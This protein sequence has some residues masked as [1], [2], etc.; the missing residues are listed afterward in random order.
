MLGG[1]LDEQKVQSEKHFLGGG[2]SSKTYEVG[3][4]TRTFSSR[5][6]SHRVELFINNLESIKLEVVSK[7][8][9]F[10]FI[11]GLYHGVWTLGS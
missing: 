7:S 1:T 3:N 8:L 2:A 5:L 10:F 11:S 6:P 9:I 4:N